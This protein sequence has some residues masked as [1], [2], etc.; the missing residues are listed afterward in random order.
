MVRSKANFLWKSTI[1]LLI[2]GVAGF[3]CSAWAQ[4]SPLRIVCTTTALEAV[5]A[6]VGQ[7][8]VE[9][10][11]IIPEQ[12]CPG[13]YDLTPSLVQK[14][15]QADVVCCHDFEQKS[16]IDKLI[17]MSGNPDL[18]IKRIAVPGSWMVPDVQVRAV[19]QVCSLLSKER[20][21]QA[22]L[23]AHNAAQYT[24]QV[25]IESIRLK[26]RLESLGLRG[27]SVVASSMQQDLLRW[28]GF[29][30]VGTYLREEDVT[31]RSFQKVIERSRSRNVVFVVDNLQ[32]G[33]EIG[34]PL[35]NELRAKHIVFSSFPR[36]YG[37]NVSYL[38]TLQEN[39]KPIIQE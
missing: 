5:V 37:K 11:S 19:E 31:V 7:D 20:P 12:S 33:A 3:F 34:A 15:R 24:K 4:G 36:A 23:F 26:R 17:R 6:A 2:G 8:L 18:D 29:V 30:V 1:L 27:S 35:A 38:K 16:F 21:Q 32:S 25:G 13:Q 39:L 14:L 9:V 10:S 22:A 28:M